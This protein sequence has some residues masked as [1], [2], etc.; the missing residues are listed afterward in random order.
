[1]RRTFVI[2]PSRRFLRGRYNV[3]KADVVMALG[4]DRY[5][6]EADIR[7]ICTKD[8]FHPETDLPHVEGARPSV[9]YSHAHLSFQRA[10]NA[11]ENA[12]KSRTE[13]RAFHSACPLWLAGD[14]NRRITRS[15]PQVAH[16]ASGVESESLRL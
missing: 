15:R 6:D 11:Y 3:L 14:H 5:A 10:A 16:A 9:I 8:R 12:P 2:V 1:M 13:R 7:S 4:N